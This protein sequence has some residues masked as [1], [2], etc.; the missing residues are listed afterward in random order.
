[1]GYNRWIES[2]E[3]G[4]IFLKTIVQI[5]KHLSILARGYTE[6]SSIEIADEDLTIFIIE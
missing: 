2:L 4:K 5:G 6:F 1:M 3:P